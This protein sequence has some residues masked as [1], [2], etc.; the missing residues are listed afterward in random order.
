MGHTLITTMH[1]W[2]STF[3]IEFTQIQKDFYVQLE[4]GTSF[5]L[6][7]FKRHSTM[8]KIYNKL[9]CLLFV[10]INE[11]CPIASACVRVQQQP[12]FMVL[13][14]LL[15]LL[16]VFSSSFISYLIPFLL[17]QVDFVHTTSAA[18]FEKLNIKSTAMP[19]ANFIV[20]YQQ[21]QWGWH[22]RKGEKQQTQSI[23]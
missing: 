8:L 20:K 6:D 3:K 9:I 4:N 19:L 23:W 7:V 12:T 16:F 13:L 1:C 17:L 22:K 10:N 5:I 14:F 2:F 21:E 18:I 11:L 15:L